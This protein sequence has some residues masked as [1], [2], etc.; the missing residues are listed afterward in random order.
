MQAK[1]RLVSFSMNRFFPLRPIIYVFPTAHKKKLRP[2]KV[3]IADGFGLS[4]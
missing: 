4:L 2:N 3:G 1:R